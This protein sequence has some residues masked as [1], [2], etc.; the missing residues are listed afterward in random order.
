MISSLVCERILI[1]ND[2]NSLNDDDSG[3]ISGPKKLSLQA[4][5]ALLGQQWLP[6]LTFTILDRT[7]IDINAMQHTAM[8]TRG[9]VAYHLL[10]GAMGTLNRMA[11]LA[12]NTDKAIQ[13][14]GKP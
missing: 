7:S 1:L 4:Q 12:F 11:I 8:A 6:G 2:V 5:H 10:R 9:E 3:K 13:T 14:S